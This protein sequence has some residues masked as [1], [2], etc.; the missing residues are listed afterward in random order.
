MDNLK[1]L[2]EKVENNV[3]TAEQLRSAA[4]KIETDGKAVLAPSNVVV[5][6]AYAHDYSAYLNELAEKVEKDNQP[7]IEKLNTLDSLIAPEVANV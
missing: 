3:R 2:I 4:V 5:Q 6:G 1:A 7:H